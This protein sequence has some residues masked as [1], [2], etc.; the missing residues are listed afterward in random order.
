MSEKTEAI[1]RCLKKTYT[2]WVVDLRNE[3]YARMEEARGDMSR[4]AFLK[5]LLENYQK[6]K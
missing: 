5:M 2:R 4:A 3:D 1:R 6:S